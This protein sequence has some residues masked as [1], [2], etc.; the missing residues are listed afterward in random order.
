MATLA[1]F[2]H[3]FRSDEAGASDDDN[4]QVFVPLLPTATVAVDVRGDCL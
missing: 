1:E 2:P 4:L 3:E